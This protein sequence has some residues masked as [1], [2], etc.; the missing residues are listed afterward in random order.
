MNIPLRNP[1]LA[2]RRRLNARNVSLDDSKQNEIKEVSAVRFSRHRN[3]K[4]LVI[5]LG[6]AKYSPSRNM[7]NFTTTRLGLML[8]FGKS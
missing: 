7:Y 2:V 5:C 1:E 6:F 4:Y 8:R 3:R